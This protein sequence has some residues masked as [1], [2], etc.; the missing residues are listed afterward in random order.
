MRPHQPTLLGNG[1]RRLEKVGPR[2]PAQGPVSFGE[3]VKDARHR[4]RGGPVLV[5]AVPDHKAEAVR[6]FADVAVG[7]HV[8]ACG[9]R[10]LAQAA[11]D[12]LPARR[13]IVGVKDS[14]PADAAHD[15]IDDT[16]DEGACKH[17]IQRVPTRC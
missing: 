13:G 9:T 1:N 7:P 6:G 15:R 14:E 17:R 8:C 10:A 3:D 4:D 16:L 11:P 2:H 5:D 12:D